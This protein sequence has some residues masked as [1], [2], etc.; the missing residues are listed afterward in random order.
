[1]RRIVRLSTA[2]IVCACVLSGGT[3]VHTAVTVVMSGLD[4]PRGLAFGPEGALY[5]VEAGRGGS[6]PCQTLRGLLRCYGATGAVSRYWNGTQERVATGLP[7]YAGSD[8]EAT[9]PHDISFQGRGGAFITI[10][11]GGDPRTARSGF[12]PGGDLFGMLVQA[13]ASGRWRAVADISAH[14]V[15]KN[16]DGFV[17]D[18]NPYGVLAEP[19]RQIVTDA[20]GNSLLQ[21]SANGDITTLAVFPARPG[22]STDAVPTAVVRGPDGAYYVSELTGVPFTEGAA[23]VYRVV[24]GQAPTVFRS[25]FKTIIDLTFGPD[26]SLYVLQHATGATF[27][28]GPGQLIRVASNGTRTVVVSDLSRPASVVVDDDGTIFISNRGT[29]VGTGEVLRID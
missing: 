21:V 5:V 19:S 1:M 17:V 16:P 18:T 9:G 27:F 29:S 8:N 25:G 28:G 23:N 15:D 2:I 14:E 3:R 22:R 13:P 10:G 7:S 24:P 20:G 12:G 26:G 11:L 6:G 4:N